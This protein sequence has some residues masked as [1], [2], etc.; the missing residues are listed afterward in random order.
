MAP[1]GQ[2][3]SAGYFRL[4]LLFLVRGVTCFRYGFQTRLRNGIAAVVRQSVTAF[5]DLLQCPQYRLDVLLGLGIR[6]DI[7]IG[8]WLDRG[9]LGRIISIV[10]ISR[11]GIKRFESKPRTLGVALVTAIVIQHAF[12]ALTLASDEFVIQPG[13]VI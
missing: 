12:Q 8:L 11:F 2:R 4:V 10:I 7:K 13:V 5:I 1:L 3:H 6:G 9:L